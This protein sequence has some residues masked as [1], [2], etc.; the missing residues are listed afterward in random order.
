MKNM[1]VS[2]CI[3]LIALA[4][5]SGGSNGNN[6]MDG[7]CAQA[8]SACGGSVTGKWKSTSVCGNSLGSVCKE[9]STTTTG[10][11]ILTFDAA[12]T[13]SGD[14][15]GSTSTSRYPPSCFTTD[16]GLFMSCMQLSQALAASG[17]SCTGGGAMDCV[18]TSQAMMG[19]GNAGTWSVMGSSLTLSFMNPMGSQT[20]SYCVQG[21]TLKLQFGGGT[22]SPFFY[23]L[24]RQ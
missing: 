10:S 20:T 13:F 8:F 11:V 6:T 1:R 7:E 23:I 24:T 22:S 19:V 3:A 14:Y 5:C 4:S 17:G 18:C 16:G 2:G 15:S 9:A 12:G 21:D